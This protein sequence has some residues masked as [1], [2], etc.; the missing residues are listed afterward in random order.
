MPMAIHELD[1]EFHRDSDSR[2]A[3]GA[4]LLRCGIDS[5]HSIFML[6]GGCLF[7]KDHDLALSF[8]RRTIGLTSFDLRCN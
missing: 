7:V 5:D 8:A 3:S 2:H 4:L 1:R 6:S